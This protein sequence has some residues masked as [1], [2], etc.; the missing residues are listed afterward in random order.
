MP[1]SSR[2]LTCWGVETRA[3]RWL[4]HFLPPHRRRGA[5]LP[6]L[7][8]QVAVN[9][10]GGIVTNAGP[11][12]SYSARRDGCLSR[13]TRRLFDGHRSPPPVGGHCGRW[14]SRRHASCA[15]HADGRWRTTLRNRCRLARAAGERRRRS[16][17]GFSTRHR[18]SRRRAYRPAAAARLLSC[19]RAPASALHRDRRRRGSNP[20]RH[21]GR[22][23]DDVG[24]RQRRYRCYRSRSRRRQY[25][26]SG[27]AWTFAFQPKPLRAHCRMRDCRRRPQRHC[28]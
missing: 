22:A 26:A 25:S 11:E 21:V 15:I 24:H 1:P 12:R 18:P 2:L 27:A 23:V 8:R 28:A 7:S 5:A 4:R 10:H 16:N 14:R 13:C 17:A 19:R 20:H 9:R 6:R 3:P